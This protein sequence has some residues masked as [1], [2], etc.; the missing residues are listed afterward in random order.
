MAVHIGPT[1]VARKDKPFPDSK[2]N[3]GGKE[4]PVDVQLEVAG[5]DIA[6]LH[7]AHHVLYESDILSGEYNGRLQ[8]AL[9]GLETPPADDS[10]DARI[11]LA[12]CSILLPPVGDSALALFAVRPQVNSK[13]I[14]ARIA[15]VHANRILQTARARIKVGES[16]TNDAET[17][18]DV[19]AE[20][21]IHARDDDLEERREYDVAI[22]VSDIGGKLHL[23]VQ[24]N[25]N[26]IPV[27]LDDLGEPIKAIRGALYNVA[28]KWDYSKPM[29]LQ[30][31]FS[32]VL[33]ALAARG[34]SLKLHLRER[35]GND[36]DDW[37]RIHLVPKTDEFLPLEYVY[38][39]PPP[40]TDA[41]VVSECRDSAQG[42]RLR[43]RDRGTGQKQPLPE[44]V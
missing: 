42:W 23:T 15:V 16:T 17:Q 25:G 36:I 3:F 32:D 13:E 5:A 20:E 4:V 11:G 9:R 6:P 24:R 39:G 31:A 29:I 37:E 14:D 34:T 18:L 21:T 22:Q 19:V 41:T 35:C 43:L 1:S 7:P 10:N 12:S 40:D 8:K 26:A 28:I 44:S 2:I 38:D 33:Y 30:D 27:Q